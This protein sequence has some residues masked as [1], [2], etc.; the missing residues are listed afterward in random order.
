MSKRF[1]SQEYF[2]YPRLGKK[3]RRPVGHQSKMRI[4]KGGSGRVVS[5]GYR[6]P[7]V[8]RGKIAGADAALVRSTKELESLSKEAVIIAS[9]VG[10]RKTLEI[11]EKAKSMNVRIMNMKKVKA[12]RKTA[13][14][15]A[16][17]KVVN[18]KAQEEK[19]MKVEKKEEHKHERHEHAKSHKHEADT[20]KK[21]DKGEK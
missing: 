17:K 10:A 9:G 11:A 6:T 19:Q 18:K 16:E 13:K 8:L 12:A 20:E 7:A 14:R 15:I 21:E 2:R 4:H 5:I 1:K 3:W